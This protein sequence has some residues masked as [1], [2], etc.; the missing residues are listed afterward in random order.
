MVGFSKSNHD[1]IVSKAIEFEGL[2]KKYDIHEKAFAVKNYMVYL[3]A[4]KENPGYY[5]L[6]QVNIGENGETSTQFW[7]QK[8]CTNA[9]RLEISK[10]VEKAIQSGF[11]QPIVNVQKPL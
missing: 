6:F 11:K 8:I 1:F 3:V 4:F 10:E 9:E 7:N 5:E 2:G